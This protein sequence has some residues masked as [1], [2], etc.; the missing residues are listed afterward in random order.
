[1]DKIIESVVRNEFGPREAQ[2]QTG[3]PADEEVHT[4]SG[5][6]AINAQRTNAPSYRTYTPHISFR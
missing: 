6:W 2:E 4:P 3:M 1:M 5:Q